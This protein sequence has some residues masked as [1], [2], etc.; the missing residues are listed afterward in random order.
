MTEEIKT[1]RRSRDVIDGKLLTA[2][3]DED[4]VAVLMTKHDLELVIL[5]IGN[6]AGK[7]NS[8]ATEMKAGLVD[9]LEGAFPK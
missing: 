4:V 2:L 3:E 7:G 8:R 9:L 1:E 5:A 6:V